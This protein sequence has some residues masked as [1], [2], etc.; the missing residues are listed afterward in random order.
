[1]KNFESIIFDM[2]GLLLDSERIGLVTFQQTCQQFAL[3]DKTDLF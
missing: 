3:G 1:M 2:D